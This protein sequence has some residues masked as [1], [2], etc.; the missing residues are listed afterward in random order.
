MEDEDENQSMECT[1]IDPL[2]KLTP[3]DGNL[4]SNL[5]FWNLAGVFNS[6]N[7]WTG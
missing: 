2:Y 7:S 1:G 4:V 6:K 5:I 3:I